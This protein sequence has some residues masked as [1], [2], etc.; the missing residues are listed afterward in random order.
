MPN[1]PDAGPPDSASGERKFYVLTPVAL[2][3]TGVSAVRSLRAVLVQHRWLVSGILVA[4][5]VTGF[6]HALLMKPVYRVEV[7]LAPTSTEGGAS[8]LGAVAGQFGSLA[9]L[10]GIPGLTGS[11]TQEAVAVLQS[12]ALTAQFIRQHDLLTVLFADDWDSASGKWNLADEEV[13][14]VTDGV[15]LFDEAIRSVSVDLDTGLVTLFVEW[16]DPIVAAEWANELV[17]LLN[18][19]LREREMKEAA[20]SLEYL[21]Q[22]LAKSDVVELRTALFKLVEEQ[23]KRLMLASVHEEYAF[24]V[25]DPA[26]PPEVDDPIRPR[27]VVILLMAGILGL[28]FGTGAALLRELASGGASSPGAPGDP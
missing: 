2:G 15:N 4:F 22:Q 13:P 24:R 17:A 18:R 23:E 1:R 7:T 10:A 27:R 5:L 8:G 19:V 6:V 3:I 21:H 9:A 14:T 16:T 28:V 25:L 12:H 26:A 11:N 20:R